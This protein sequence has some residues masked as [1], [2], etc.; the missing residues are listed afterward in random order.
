MKKNILLLIVSSFF[1][2]FTACDKLDSPY[3]VEQGHDIPDPEEVVRK[4]LLEEFT[5]HKCPNCPKGSKIAH[6]L[7][8]IHGEQLV[9]LTI[10]AGWYAQTEPGM[11]SEDFRTTAGTA[12]YEDFEQ[13]PTPQGLVNR[14]Q[15]AGKTVLSINQWEPALLEQLEMEPEASITINVDYNS[16]NRE[17]SVNSETIFLNDVTGEFSVCMFI[18]EDSIV[19]PQVNND[20]DLGPSPDWEDY[21]H[22]HVL[23][24]AITGAWGENIN[25]GEDIIPEEPY[26]SKGSVVLDEDWRENHCNIVAFVYRNDTK[27]VIQA[28]EVSVIGE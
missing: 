3:L 10:H 23:R 21:V 4:V 27:Q 28:E 2:L 26:E 16:T 7:K 13:P 14:A 25:P 5:G 19:S 12:I 9:V 24:K 8:A 15:Y 6:D 17:V 11:Y 1:F 18:T 22:E 20:P